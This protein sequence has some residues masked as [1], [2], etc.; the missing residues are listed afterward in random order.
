MLI[1]DP[2][3]TLASLETNP[4]AAV[5]SDFALAAKAPVD[6][7]DWHWDGQE[8]PGRVQNIKVSF[9]HAERSA[10]GKIAS[11]D[12][13]KCRALRSTDSF[14]RRQSAFIATSCTC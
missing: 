6:V 1:F 2:D 11:M 13:V 10:H 9:D 12:Q 8:I 14:P 7:D 4:G 5:Y 3:A